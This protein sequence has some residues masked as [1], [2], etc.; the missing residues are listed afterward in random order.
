M[1][2]TFRAV[3][4]ACHGETA[5]TVTG[6]H[7][8]RTDLV[9]TEPG[10]AMGFLGLKLDDAAN[11]QNPLDADIAAPTSA[12]RVLIIRAEEDWA[13]ARECWKIMAGM[14]TE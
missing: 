10:S 14:V 13:I 9:P 12:V 11:A 4:L 1:S 3:Y 6:Q 5:W 7:T 2:E 8:G